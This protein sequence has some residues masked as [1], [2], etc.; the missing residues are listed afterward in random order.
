MYM[1]IIRKTK[2]R[3]IETILVLHS[4]SSRHSLVPVRRIDYY[5]FSVWFAEIYVRHYIPKF[6]LVRAIMKGV[7]NTVEDV[8]FIITATECSVLVAVWLYGC[9]LLVKEIRKG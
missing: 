2:L 6:F 5:H 1:T 4:A 8:G 7:R 3:R 9:H